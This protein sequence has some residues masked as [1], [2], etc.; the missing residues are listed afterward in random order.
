M[1]EHIEACRLCA[2]FK[3]NAHALKRRHHRGF[4]E[5]SPRARETMRATTAKKHKKM[6][7]G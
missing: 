6:R 2:N 7:F 3:K 5:N 1:G 4:N